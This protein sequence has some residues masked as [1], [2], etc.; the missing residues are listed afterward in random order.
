MRRIPVLTAP[1]GF[2]KTTNAELVSSEAS[3]ASEGLIIHVKDGDISGHLR[4]V[5]DS[6]CPGETVKFFEEIR[7]CSAPPAVRVHR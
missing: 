7:S 4:K 5:S 1:R 3:E 2:C 6:A